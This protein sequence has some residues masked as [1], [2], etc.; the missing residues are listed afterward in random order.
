MLIKKNPG[1]ASKYL[2]LNQEN[3]NS[4]EITF[5]YFFGDIESFESQIIN[6]PT[7][8]YSFLFKVDSYGKKI[9]L[10]LTD[11]HKTT[12]A[13]IHKKIFS[14]TTVKIN[15]SNVGEI[16]NKSIYELREKWFCRLILYRKVYYLTINYGFGVTGSI[17][18]FFKRYFR[19]TV[20]DGLKCIG[21]IKG[22]NL[23]LLPGEKDITVK[24]YEKDELMP[25]LLLLLYKLSFA[26]SVEVDD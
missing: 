3:C 4:M 13:K 14:N 20:S 10:A 9:N 24:V 26:R 5:K 1:Y 21:E 19:Y 11:Q 23:Y 16:R 12:S 6:F 8:E 22:P 17:E 25:I 7:F 18:R 2:R 15:E